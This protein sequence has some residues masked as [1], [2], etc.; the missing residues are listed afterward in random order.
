MSQ[1]ISLKCWTFM[2]FVVIYETQWW[3]AKKQR[4]VTVRVFGVPVWRKYE[5]QS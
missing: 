4:R 1:W 5:R 3:P 2:F